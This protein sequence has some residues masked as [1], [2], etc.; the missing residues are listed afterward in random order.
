MLLDSK[1]VFVRKDR[2]DVGTLFCS[3]KY[4]IFIVG[5]G[6]FRQLGHGAVACAF[7]E[8]GIV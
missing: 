7:H 1:K 6:F 5:S 4:Y 2:H 8:F 3:S